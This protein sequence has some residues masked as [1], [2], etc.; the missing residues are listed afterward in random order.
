MAAAAPFVK[1]LRQLSQAEDDYR[2]GALD[3][4]W[5][6]GRATIYVVFGQPNHALYQQNGEEELEGPEAISALVHHLPKR[7]KVA[8]WRREVVRTESVHM[9]MAE[10]ME[11]FAQL[12]GGRATPP[13]RREADPSPAAALDDN[14]HR[15]PFGLQDFPLLPVGESLWADGSAAIVHLDQLLPQLPDCLV[16]LTGARLRAAAIVVRGSIIDAVWVDDEDQASGETA[17]MAL[18]GAREGRISGYRLEDASIAEALTLLWR[19]PYAYESMPLEWLDPVFVAGHWTPQLIEM[20][21]GEDALGLT[22]EHSEQMAWEDVVAARPD[23]VVVMPCGYD[24]E[25]SHEEAMRHA[26][27]LAEIGARRVVAVDAAGTFSR[28]GPRLV[29]ALEL[30]AHILHPG[31]VPEAPSVARD[32]ELVRA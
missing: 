4:T 16:V 20:A 23:V 18:I 5:D 9:S 31:A 7:F 6:E 27:R 11:P 2:S 8:P 12:E 15:V 28:P 24:L 21:G 14:E 3:I 32:V 25:R 13:P 29:D 19:C 17:A 10:L 1:L 30:M 26:D 22:G